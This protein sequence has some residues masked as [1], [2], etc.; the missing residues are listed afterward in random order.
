MKKLRFIKQ[1]AKRG[2]ADEDAWDIHCWFLE[3]I[4]PMLKQLK[5]EKHGYPCDMTEEEW[6]KELDEMI[7]NFTEAHEETC[8]FENKY[9]KQHQEAIH[10]FIEKYGIFGEGLATEEEIKKQKETRTIRV[11]SMVELPEYQEIARNWLDEEIKKAKYIDN[12][13]NKAFELFSKYFW[14]LWD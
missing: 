4:V 2:Y 12:C 1:R 5:Q 13:K 11:H 7:F 14:D 10:E 9:E 8:S 6:D 3:T